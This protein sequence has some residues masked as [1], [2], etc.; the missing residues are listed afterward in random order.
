MYEGK[1]AYTLGR[2]YEL[3]RKAFEEKRYDT[4]LAHLENLVKE[5]AGYADAFNMLGLIYYNRGRSG[6]AV[7]AFKKA[8]VT[9]PAYTEAAMNLAVIYNEMGKLDSARLVY[10]RAKEGGKEA[11]S[12]LD[13]YVKGKLANMHAALGS[14]YKELGLNTEATSDYKN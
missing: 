2:D 13:P 14:I 9:N 6:E 12:Y 1:E 5:G 3:G 7:E 4:A 10:A 8:L 11:R